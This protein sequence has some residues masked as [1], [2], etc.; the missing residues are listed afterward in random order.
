MATLQSTNVQGALCVNGVAVGGGKDFKFCCFTASSTFTPTQDLVD[1]NGFLHADIIGGG[2]GGG[3][4]AAVGY[5]FNETNLGLDL[6]NACFQAAPGGFIQDPVLPITSTTACGVTIGAG[7]Q[8]GSAVI[9]SCIYDCGAGAAAYCPGLITL[10]AA[11]KGGN[12]CF[13]NYVAYG[14]QGGSS[15]GRT[16]VPPNPYNCTVVC[17]GTSAD[18]N[19]PTYAGQSTGIDVSVDP[20]CAIQSGF[21]KKC[22]DINTGFNK[23]ECQQFGGSNFGGKMGAS[24]FR[25]G[26]GRCSADI[27]GKV[28]PFRFDTGARYCLTCTSTQGCYGCRVDYSFCSGSVYGSPGGDF[29]YCMAIGS[30]GNCRTKMLMSGSTGPGA[31]GIVV[32]KWQE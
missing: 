25:C 8:S 27:L 6:N 24:G 2:G 19:V 15:V 31:Q 9:A 23:P 1:G 32:L 29:C 28:V 13:G 11:D 17:A 12:S 26:N 4:A 22:I 30:Y 14:G 16:Y 5:C 18:A 21:I 10:T 3:A 20:A 7:G